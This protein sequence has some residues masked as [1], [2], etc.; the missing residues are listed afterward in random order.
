MRKQ[1]LGFITL[2]FLVIALAGCGGDAKTPKPSG[3]LPPPRDVEQTPDLSS[4]KLEITD[5][6]LEGLTNEKVPSTVVNALKP[7]QGTTYKNAKPFIKDVK[8]AIGAEAFS[9]HREA[10]LRHAAVITLAQEPPFPGKKLSLTGALKNMGTPPFRPVF[11][12][13]DRSNIK[14]KFRKVIKAN[15]RFLL[16]NSDWKVDVEGHADKRGTTEYNL[17]LGERRAEAVKRALLNEG[18]NP[19]QL[20]VLTRGEEFPAKEGSSEGSFRVNRRA[21]LSKK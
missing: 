16:N 7:L 4:G 21:V 15:A 1:R 12:D 18:V 19:D 11:F 13:Y 6:T 8:E 5:K 9:Q 10:I 17:A 20:K 3:N 14:P 2:A